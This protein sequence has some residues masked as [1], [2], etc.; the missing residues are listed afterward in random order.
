MDMHHLL[1]EAE[2]WVALGLVLFGL[3]VVFAK[4]PGLVARNLDTR[5]DAIR[6]ALAE[7]EALREDARKQLAELTARRAELEGQAARMLADAETEAKRLEAEAKVKLE[8]QIKRRTEMA[9]RRIALAETQ[10]TAEVKAAAVDLA[11]KAAEQVLA[12]RTAALGADPMVDRAV[13]E[14]GTRLQ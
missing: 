8:E 13:A 6:T 10:A 14:L 1:N 9:D 2:F 5:S 11:V 3:I 12:R 7:A 4:V